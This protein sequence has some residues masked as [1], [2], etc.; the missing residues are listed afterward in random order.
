LK[1]LFVFLS[2]L[3]FGMLY[4]ILISR[5]TLKKHKPS[6]KLA[7]INGKRFHY[8]CIGQGAPTVVMDSALGGNFLDWSWIQSEISCVTKVFSYDR[9]GYGWSEPSRN[10]RTSEVIVEELRELLVKVKVPPP[11]ILVG[12]SF[13]GL[14]MRLYQQ[15]YPEEVK[16]LVLV[17]STPEE[18]YSTLPKE[19]IKKLT[20]ERKMIQIARFLAPFGILRLLKMP[21]GYSKLPESKKTISNAVGYNTNAY[22]TA[23]KELSS[24]QQSISQ[25]SS[26]K[27]DKQISIPLYVISRNKFPQGNMSNDTLQRVQ[28]CWSKLQ[29]DI[30]KSSNKSKHI[31]AE[32]SG[33]FIHC[34]EP[35]KVIELILE[36]IDDIKKQKLA[37]DNECFKLN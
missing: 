1:I 18:I 37:V 10:S 11:Y 31:I 24:M 7:E 25:L 21:V 34:D 12:H 13:G 3:F 2:I 23:Y 20:M 32:N 27:S 22:T 35:D 19:Y 14:N 36:M 5:W 29:N 15:K 33:H 6:G 30:A 4:Q 9:A 26:L 28:E 8:Y 17:D 16:G